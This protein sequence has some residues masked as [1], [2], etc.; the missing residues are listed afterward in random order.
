MTVL[1]VAAMI[2]GMV[3]DIA[4]IGAVIAYTL[5]GPSQ[6]DPLS[7]KTHYQKDERGTTT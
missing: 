6:P 1:S 2:L 7:Q 3:R 4:L 5:W